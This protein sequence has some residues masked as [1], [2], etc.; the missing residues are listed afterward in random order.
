MLGK[1]KLQSWRGRRSSIL[2]GI[3]RDRFAGI[4]VKLDDKND[5]IVGKSISN[6]VPTYTYLRLNSTWIINYQHVYPPLALSSILLE[7]WLWEE[8]IWGR[9]VQHAASFFV[10][11]TKTKQCRNQLYLNASFM[12][13]QKWQE[14]VKKIYNCSNDSIFKSVFVSTF[15]EIFP[16][17]YAIW[18]I[19]KSFINVNWLSTSIN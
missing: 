19:L 13:A 9:M 15:H 16:E 5:E 11:N 14:M 12:Y 7:S 18:K 8:A 2:Q 17:I 10:P 4:T 6:T 1:L 3:G